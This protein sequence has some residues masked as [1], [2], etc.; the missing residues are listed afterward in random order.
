MQPAHSHLG[1]FGS[2]LRGHTPQTG[3]QV[4]SLTFLGQV[5]PLGTGGVP[6]SNRGK[7]WEMAQTVFQGLVPVCHFVTSDKQVGSF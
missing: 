4:F 7:C 6:A 1:E 3:S 2:A 5:N